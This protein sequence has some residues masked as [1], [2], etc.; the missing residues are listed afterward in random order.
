MAVNI[1]VE[2][3]WVVTPCNVVVGYQRFR[4]PCCLHLQGEDGGV[5]IQTASPW[6]QACYSGHHCLHYYLLS[7]GKWDLP[8]PRK[9]AHIWNVGHN[10]YFNKQTNV[11]W[12][13]SMLGSIRNVYCQMTFC[14]VTSLSLSLSPKL[15]IS[16]YGKA[17]CVCRN[18]APLFRRTNY[19]K[20]LY[21]IQ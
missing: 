18:T 21:S 8:A 5:T 10:V 14:R 1:E 17:T 3:F 4:G 20:S 7:R 15:S 9:G 19:V 16:V 12:P 6:V 13:Q 2:V 11:N